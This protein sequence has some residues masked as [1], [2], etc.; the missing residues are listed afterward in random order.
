MQSV[1]DALGREGFA[2]L[3]R[4]LDD[5]ELASA[6]AAASAH[7]DGHGARSDLGTIAVDLSRHTPACAALLPRLAA[8]VRALLGEPS[9]VLFQDL[10]VDKLRGREP[11]TWHRDAAHLPLDDD[12]GLIM[13]VALDDAS[14]ADGC[15]RY[16]AGSQASRD[17]GSYDAAR[18]APPVP[19]AVVAAPVIAG[20]ALVHSLRIWHDSPASRTGRQRRGWSLWWVRPNA[21]WAPARTDHPFLR[22]LS[23]AAGDSLAVDRFPRF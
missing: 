9:V 17:G 8:P 11:V 14:E 15:L 1:R 23:P 7:L 6:R 21:R 13:W 20:E 16:I 3:G 22:E 2:N 12:D 18:I 10:V 4:V 5:A 19:G